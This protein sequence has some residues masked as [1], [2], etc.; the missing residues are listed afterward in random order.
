MRHPLLTK[1]QYSYKPPYLFDVMHK[2][3]LIRLG[4]IY[5]EY[6]TRIGKKFGPPQIT[7]KSKAPLLVGDR[8]RPLLLAK[9]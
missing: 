3:R 2:A 6:Y 9:K 7:D 1:K 8:I 5:E 4:P